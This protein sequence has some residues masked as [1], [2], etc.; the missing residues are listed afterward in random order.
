MTTEN[1]R[2]AMVVHDYFEQV[3]MTEVRQLLEAEDIDVDLIA[4]EAD[5][6]HGLHH[7][8]LGDVFTVDK[9]IDEVTT[10]DY[11]AVVLP[12]GVVNGDQLRIVE[13][14]L[15]FIQAMYNDDKPI[16]AIC[17]APWVLISAGLADGHTMTSYKTLRDDIQNADGIW[18]DQEVVTDGN[19]ITSRNPNDIPAFAH[20]IIDAL[21]D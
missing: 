21:N 18:V 10:S 16:A 5:E 15:D 6:V 12:G 7:V 3:E 4:T 13:S 19:I 9:T 2:V 11:S 1:K 14:A 20:A 8:E 17:H